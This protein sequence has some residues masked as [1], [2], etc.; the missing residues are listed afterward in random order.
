M[1]LRGPEEALIA[2]PLGG[3]V[4]SVRRP[5]AEPPT[6]GID[7]PGMAWKMLECV[8]TDTAL[9]LLQ[10]LRVGIEQRPGGSVASDGRV[11]P[12]L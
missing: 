10:S 8:E 12:R 9:P 1:R 6:R 11:K 7:Q 2:E 3:H 5:R 4:R